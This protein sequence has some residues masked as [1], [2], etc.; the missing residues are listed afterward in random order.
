MDQINLDR[1]AIC[2]DDNVPQQE[3]FSLACG[4]WYHTACIRTWASSRYHRT[5]PF[6]ETR[7]CEEELHRLEIDTSND[8]D[9]DWEDTTSDSTAEKEHIFDTSQEVLE[10]IEVLDLL[11]KENETNL[12]EITQRVRSR[13]TNI[14]QLEQSLEDLHTVHHGKI[15]PDA[16]LCHLSER[17]RKLETELAESS[18]FSI[19]G[20]R[21]AAF[22][23]CL[24]HAMFLVLFQLTDIE[25]V[26]WEGTIDRALG[27]Q[28]RMYT[29][30]KAY[31]T[32][33]K[34]AEEN[35]ERIESLQA[36]ID[37]IASKNT[38]S[39]V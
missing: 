4:H 8:Q 9:D 36:K 1:C 32:I 20:N 16:E 12:E 3:K 15:I 18:S 31:G 34:L 26:D 11:R 19:T 14:V 13:H 25:D 27:L 39:S 24:D 7:L 38:S 17:L 2:L 29:V 6:C 10:S 5:C 30:I 33:S 23:R 22:L 21:N 28:S 37:D 35:S